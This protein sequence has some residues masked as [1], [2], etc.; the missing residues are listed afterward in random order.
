MSVDYYCKC[1][2][3]EYIDPTEK[4]DINGIV[5]IAELTKILMK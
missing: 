4:M 1:K 5:H 3:C 2:D